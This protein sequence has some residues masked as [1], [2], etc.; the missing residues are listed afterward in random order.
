SWWRNGSSI[1]SLDGNGMESG[2]GANRNTG[3]ENERCIGRVDYSK[4]GEEGQKNWLGTGKDMMDWAMSGIMGATLQRQH[5]IC[6]PLPCD[7][8]LT[9]SEPAA[10]HS[11]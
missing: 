4:R 1:L 5:A 7:V 2:Q 8:G 6:D 9:S 10:S 11:P 3:C